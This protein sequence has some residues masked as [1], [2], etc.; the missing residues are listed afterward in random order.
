MQRPSGRRANDYFSYYWCIALY[1]ASRDFRPGG[2]IQ[3]KTGPGEMGPLLYGGKR[4]ERLHENMVLHA[5]TIRRHAGRD[6]GNGRRAAG[7]DRNML[8]T[9]H[10]AGLDPGGVFSMR[11]YPRPAADLSGRLAASSG[12]TNNKPAHDGPVFLRRLRVTSPAAVYGVLCF[13]SIRILARHYI[14]GAGRWRPPGGIRGR[15]Y[16]RG[17]E[18]RRPPGATISWKMARFLA[19]FTGFGV[20]KKSGQPLAK[21]QKSQKS[22]DQSRK[23]CRAPEKSRAQKSKVV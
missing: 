4:N 7:N 5:G 1:P 22:R 23:S 16:A 19:F 15:L 8:N 10:A 2:Q 21:T 17:Q 12:A 3:I 13:Y 14:G 20:T 11:G 9:I 18:G 6:P